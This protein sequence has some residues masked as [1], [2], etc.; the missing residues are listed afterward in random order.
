MKDLLRKCEIPFKSKDSKGA[1]INLARDNN[2]AGRIWD[3]I[4]AQHTQEVELFGKSPIS[5]AQDR[6][7]RDMSKL[8]EGQPSIAK[9][10][11]AGIPEAS[12]FWENP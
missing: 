12:V 7:L 10:L 1:L 11:Q 9:G 8:V 6:A 2:L 5:A 3:E 4:K